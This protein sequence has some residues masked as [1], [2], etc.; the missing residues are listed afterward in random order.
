VLTPIP[1]RPKG[2][3]FIQNSKN[4]RFNH[5]IIKSFTF[6]ET[7]LIGRMIESYSFGRQTVKYIMK[8]ISEI[9]CIYINVWPIFS[10]YLIARA[11][12]KNSLP[13]VT[14]VQDIY[15]ESLYN[16]YRILSNLFKKVLVPVDRYVLKN[17]SKVIAISEN[18][19]F[20]LN[21][22]RNIPPEKIEL[23]HNWNN[24]RIQLKERKFNSAKRKPGSEKA[25]FCFM[26]LGNI[27][28]VAGID[29]LI[30]SFAD[31]AIKD[32]KL[33][34]AGSGSQRDYC[35]KLAQSKKDSNI[36][37]IEVSVENTYQVL[38][39]ADVFMLPLVKDASL[40]SVP[41]KLITYMIAGKPIIASVDSGSDTARV[42]KKANCGWVVQPE[43]REQISSVMRMVRQNTK[44]IMKELGRNGQ[45]YAEENFSKEKNLA[46][47]TQI[48][49]KLSI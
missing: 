36:E 40:T 41:S 28:P 38:E 6:P 14:H 32:S 25:P 9:N 17:S 3:K 16:R 29:H 15:P 11:A 34:I 10:Q 12:K 48:I 47:L 5:V 45:V 26:Y 2:F 24:S 4:E 42:I 18:M 7:R 8:N 37:F 20:T 30:L 13:L 49:T 19:L 23:V 43:V 44:E 33:I 39:Q 21:K 46:L 31:A 22:T 35:Y 1:T 27:G